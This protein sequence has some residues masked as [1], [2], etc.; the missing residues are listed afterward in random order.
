MMKGVDTLQME[1]K[2]QVAFC[3]E[4]AATFHPPNRRL[5]PRMI[6]LFRCRCW[7]KKITNQWA[8]PRRRTEAFEAIV[9]HMSLAPFLMDPRSGRVAANENP[10]SIV[11]GVWF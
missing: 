2:H 11:A 6:G 7:P 8:R 9:G 5:P 1:K 10:M 4:I 3:Y